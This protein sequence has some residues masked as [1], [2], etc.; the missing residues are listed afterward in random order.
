MNPGGSQQLAQK[1]TLMDDLRTFFATA[2]LPATLTPRP[3][4]DIVDFAKFV[5]TNL[6]RLD[7]ESARLRGIS[8]ANLTALKN[9]LNQKHESP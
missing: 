1:L 6:A 7:C 3:W 2:I 9:L 4:M 8:V 5:D